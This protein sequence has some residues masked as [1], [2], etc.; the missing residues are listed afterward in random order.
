MN[1]VN[2]DN[3]VDIGPVTLKTT[4]AQTYCVALQL[5][6]ASNTIQG[7]KGAVYT[8]LLAEAVTVANET[9]EEIGGE[10]KMA[11]M[12]YTVV[13]AKFLA[14][15]KVAE[16]EIDANCDE[17][18]RPDAWKQAKSDINVALMA[19]FDLLAEPTVAQTALR[20]AKKDL[21]ESAQKAEQARKIAAHNKKHGI[22]EV[23]PKDGDAGGTDTGGGDADKGKKTTDT[24]PAGNSGIAFSDPE[25]Q[26]AYDLLG[27]KMK[28]LEETTG[29][30]RRER[31]GAQVALS[32]CTSA[33][34]TLD[35]SLE[36]FQAAMVKMAG[37]A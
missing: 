9:L 27:Q 3:L 10:V 21:V 34:E 36:A 16:A 8:R 11:D 35:T 17:E 13:A 14:V 15:L 24:P 5:V 7:R 22:A 28:A 4:L 26:A 20:K 23:K 37:A 31:S 12:D 18:K 19:G 1:K 25:L 6:V 29:V 33:T 32:T 30:N 2:L